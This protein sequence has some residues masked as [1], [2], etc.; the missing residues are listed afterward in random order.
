MSKFTIE[1]HDDVSVAPLAKMLAAHGYRLK[2]QDGTP[3]VELTESE[4]RT[5]EIA[6]AHARSE[7]IR[8]EF[9][10]RGWEP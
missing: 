10:E 7:R 9:M 6:A 5:A 4:E 8:H 2:R 1:V 3:V